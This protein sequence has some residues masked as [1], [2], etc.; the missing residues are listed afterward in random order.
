MSFSKIYAIDYFKIG[1]TKLKWW[2]KKKGMI[3]V[4]SYVKLLFS[5]KTTQFCIHGLP[6]STTM[7]L[8]YLKKLSRTDVDSAQKVNS[9]AFTWT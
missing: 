2:K 4:L 1:A 5:N 7:Q 9:N 3:W 6:S 8:W